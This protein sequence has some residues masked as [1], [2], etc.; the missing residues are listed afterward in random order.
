MNVNITYIY[1]VEIGNNK[2]YIGKT[3]NPKKREKD[4]KQTYGENIQYT[5]IDQVSSLSK[6]EWKPLET[7]WIWSFISWGFDVINKNEGGAGVDF[8]TEETKK[9]IGDS[10]RGKNWKWYKENPKKRG[11]LP[12]EHKQ[13]ISQTNTGNMSQYYT[14]EVRQKMKENIKGK[15]GPNKAPRADIGKKREYDSSNRGPRSEET[16]QKIK[17][18]LKKHYKNE[19]QNNNQ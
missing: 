6:K 18:S 12:T 7:M 1:L 8:C 5:I 10:K 9:K 3:K 19:R 14:E 17:E 4:H 2:V 15:R 11:P 13:K 16:K